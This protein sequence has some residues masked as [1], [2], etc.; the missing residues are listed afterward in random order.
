MSNSHAITND[1]PFELDPISE[2]DEQQTPSDPVDTKIVD[3][4]RSPQSRADPVHNDYPVDVPN[5]SDS[6]SHHN[7]KAQI[8]DSKIRTTTLQHEIQ[9]SEMEILKT[10]RYCE[11]PISHGF[12][13]DHEHYVHRMS[14][15]VARMGSSSSVLSFQCRPRT[16]TNS[17]NYV[18]DVPEHM[19]SSLIGTPP[20]SNAR[21]LIV[22]ALSN[23]E[24][25]NGMS[26]KREQQWSVTEIRHSFDVN[27]NVE[28]KSSTPK[29]STKE[30]TDEQDQPFKEHSDTSKNGL[31]STYSPSYYPPKRPIFD[32]P[33]APRSRPPS[34]LSL[35]NRAREFQQQTA[36]EVVTA[37]NQN[38]TIRKYN[39]QRRQDFLGTKR[40]VDYNALPPDYTPPKPP[41]DDKNQQDDRISTTK[42]K[43]FGIKFE[44]PRAQKLFTWSCIAVGL[45]YLLCLYALLEWEI[46]K[47]QDLFAWNLFVFLLWSIFGILCCCA[48]Q[49]GSSK[50]AWIFLLL[51]LILTLIFGILIWIC[52][53]IKHGN[54]MWNVEKAPLLIFVFVM[55]V[56]CMLITMFMRLAFNI[57]N[58]V[59]E[60]PIKP[61]TFVVE[62][63]V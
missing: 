39:E 45:V 28:Y 6:S 58:E 57:W 9:T 42:I 61:F 25:T 8:I 60:K 3:T 34:S 31:L 35:N 13:N 52:V 53:D 44:R 62:P 19:S 47:P 63:D 30:L 51:P 55:I 20:N 16:R 26:N 37:L 17:S 11:S 14:P 38:E 59:R 29:R 49:R 22:E 24:K 23:D 21:K 56:F 4:C 2:T 10:S 27:S 43:F 36:K 54:G 1:F 33:P 32:P 7:R 40:E 50:I 48:Q 5:P 18:V 46:L 12:A 41:S 15:N